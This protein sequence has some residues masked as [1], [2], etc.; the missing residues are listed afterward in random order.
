MHNIKVANRTRK[1]LR[2]EKENG[3]RKPGFLDESAGKSLLLYQSKA[4]GVVRHGSVC[5]QGSEQISE[6]SSFVSKETDIKR[7]IQGLSD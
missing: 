1:R 3:E 4:A 7:A 2:V 5:N 6:L